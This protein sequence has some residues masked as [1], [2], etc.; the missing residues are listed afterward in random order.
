MRWNPFLRLIESKKYLYARLIRTS[1][2]ERMWDTYYVLFGGFEIFD[3]D[4]GILDYLFFPIRIIEKSL[5]ILAVK[6]PQTLQIYFSPVFILLTIPWIALNAIKA[7]TAGLLTL[8]SIPI[9]SLVHLLISPIWRKKASQIENLIVRP[10][11]IQQSENSE[12]SPKFEN[13]IKLKE[14]ENFSFNGNLIRPLTKF[15]TSDNFT[16]STYWPEDTILYLGV[17]RADYCFQF[18]NHRAPIN[19]ESHGKMRA[20]IEITTHNWQG[21]Q[22]M[23]QTNSLWSCNNLESS[24]FC[25]TNEVQDEIEKQIIPR[26]AKKAFLDGFSRTLRNHSPLKKFAEYPHF[27]PKVVGI[28]FEFPGYPKGYRNMQPSAYIAER[29]NNIRP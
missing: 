13:D 16:F 22:A 21:I 15:G 28:I 18:M 27:E 8:L 20:V 29:K 19:L 11:D 2:T 3:D 25:T 1:W 24:F 14:I 7:V 9:V 4:L 6:I 26:L 10:V 23:L 12:S 5:F 17:Y